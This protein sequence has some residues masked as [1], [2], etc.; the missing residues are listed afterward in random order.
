MKTLSGIMSDT[1]REE[2][3]EN[4]Q[5]RDRSWGRAGKIT[6]IDEV[7]DALGWSPLASG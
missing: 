6:I 3:L 1:G 5:Q 2:Y 4:C 7:N